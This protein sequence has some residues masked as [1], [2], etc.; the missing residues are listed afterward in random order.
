MMQFMNPLCSMAQIYL[1]DLLSFYESQICHKS[2]ILHLTTYV[3]LV[4]QKGFWLWQA[5]YFVL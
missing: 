3:I 5:N 2:M 1:A 4:F